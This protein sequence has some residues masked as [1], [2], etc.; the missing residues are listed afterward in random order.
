M[1]NRHTA[2]GLLTFAAVA[3][4]T[5]SACSSGGDGA[6]DGSDT[7][8][9]S[10]TADSATVDLVSDG[11]LTLCTN[12]PYEPFEWEVDGE[13]VGFD[14]S[15]VGEVAK[16]LGVPM[17]TLALGFDGLQSGAA[18]EAGT[19][20]VVAAAITITDERKQ[21]L[22]FSDPYFDAD[23]AVLVA[24]DSTVAAEGDLEGLQVGVMQATTGADWVNEQGLTAVEFEDLGLQVQALKNGTVD[25]V[26]NDI[27]ALGPF[28][29]DDL[30]VA[31][32]V[33]TGEQY[34]FGVR[35]GN[36]ALLDAMNGTLKRLHEDGGYDAIYTEFIG[37]T[38]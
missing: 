6:S 31:F 36:T 26:V 1:K 12:L 21:N 33:P 35:K 37:A 14:I 38:D 29:T 4:L 18:L 27:A 24:T 3:A 23:Q 2:P 34:G 10:G 7:A 20:D 17:K 8:D 22:D 25:A 28:T 9:G 11:E 13:I 30:K 5:L 16:D 15:L 19:C 32:T